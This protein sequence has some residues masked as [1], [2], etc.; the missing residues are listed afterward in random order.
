MNILVEKA[1]S[2]ELDLKKLETLQV[3]EITSLLI[4]KMIRLY[5]L[6]EQLDSDRLID[7][8]MAA[9]FPIFRTSVPDIRGM[10]LFT[11]LPILALR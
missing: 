1:H 4:S 8:V 7:D 11:A 9:L 6:A 5:R 2:C 3:H 10:R